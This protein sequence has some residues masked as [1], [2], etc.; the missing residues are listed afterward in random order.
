MGRWSELFNIQPDPL[1]PSPENKPVPVR[2]CLFKD[3]KNAPE[4]RTMLHEGN[5]DCSMIKAE[6]ILEVFQLLAAI[7]RAVH[8][9]KHGKLNTKGIH[10][11]I[12]YSLSPTKNITESLM[13]FG[14]GD[15]TQ[16]IVVVV[17]GDEKGEKM[18][19]V[20]RKIKGRPCHLALIKNISNYDLVKQV[21]HV[22][23][24]ELNKGTIIDAIVTRIVA[25]DYVA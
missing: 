5:L 7:N 22:K 25:K 4:L 3:V 23:D 2:I 24:P 18:S 10:S 12:V 19:K 11:E 17:V 13:T 8:C 20:A 1:D 15:E 16:N 9:E 14:I 6:L 21:Y